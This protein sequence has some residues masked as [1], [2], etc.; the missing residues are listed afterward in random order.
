M[1]ICFFICHVLQRCHP[2]HPIIRFLFY[3]NSNILSILFVKFFTIF[4][5]FPSFYRTRCMN[6]SWVYG[7]FVAYDVNMRHFF[8]LEQSFTNCKDSPNGGTK[9]AQPRGVLKKQIA[10]HD[11]RF[12]PSRSQSSQCC[13]GVPKVR[14]TRGRLDSA[15]GRWSV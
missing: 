2:F 3:Q 1:C 12:F 7:I 14:Q 10:Q 13:G 9:D 6:L 4:S 11:P 15:R 5:T 8:F